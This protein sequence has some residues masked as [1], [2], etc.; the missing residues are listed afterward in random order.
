MTSWTTRRW[1][2]AVFA[3]VGVAV[4]AA[5]PQALDVSGE[6]IMTVTTD[7]GPITATLVFKQDGEKVTGA[8]RSDQ[9]ELPLEGAVKDKTVTFSFLYTAPDGNA[10][11]VTMTGTVEGEAIS[12][13]W[14]AGG[15]V[16]GSWTAARKKSAVTSPD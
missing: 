14:D 6:W 11:T 13:T 7:G 3:V 4:A 12:G 2:W 5:Q 1:I 10:L 8:V 9:G 16:A 15:V